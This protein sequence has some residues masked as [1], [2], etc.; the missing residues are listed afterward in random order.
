MINTNID[1]CFS[2]VSGQSSV[3]SPEV[4]MAGLHRA[5]TISRQAGCGGVIV[6]EK[7]AK[8][9]QERSPQTRGEWTVFDRD[10]MK[11][12]LADHHLPAHLAKYLPEGRVSALEETLADIFGVRPSAQTLVQQSAETIL[13]F[14]ELGNVILVGRGGNFVTAKMPHVLHV[15]LVGALGDRIER[16]VHADHKTPS[17]ARKFCL[18]EDQSRAHYIKTYF[19][20]DINNPANYHLIVNTSLLGYENAAK[21]IGDAVMRL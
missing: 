11:Q 10:L 2:F 9:L 5:V 15:R 3:A 17:A 6:A 18:E 14:A 4:A 16:I 19:N 12:V 21:V 1:S 7:L 8:Y 13:K 20:A